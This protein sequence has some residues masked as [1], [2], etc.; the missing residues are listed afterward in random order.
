M[1]K[2]MDSEGNRKMYEELPDLEPGG[3]EHVPKARWTDLRCNGACM[4]SKAPFGPEMSP[5]VSINEQ[6]P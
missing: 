1:F 5:G 6:A 4:Y 2:I 3:F